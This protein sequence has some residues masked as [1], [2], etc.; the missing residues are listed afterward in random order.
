[1]DNN[2]KHQST[3]IASLHSHA[4]R[5]SSDIA[6]ADEKDSLTYEQLWTSITTKNFAD[7]SRPLWIANALATGVPFTQLLLACQYHQVGHIS[8]PNDVTPYEAERYLDDLP[9]DF[10]FCDNN[11]AWLD[12]SPAFHTHQTS[13]IANHPWQALHDGKWVQFTSG[14]TGRPKALILNQSAMNANL[15][16]HKNWLKQ[17]EGTSVF[18]PM[19]QFHAMGGA[20]LQEYL[21]AGAS[22]HVAK[23]SMPGQ[24][25]KRMQQANVRLIVA[26]PSYFRML[27]TLKALNPDSLPSLEMVEIGSASVHRSLI[28]ALLAAYPSLSIRIRYGQSEAS[29]SLTSLIINASNQHLFKDGAIGIP[30]E[31]IDISCDEH[32]KELH[33][34]APTCAT[35][36]WHDQQLKP[37]LG[38]STHELSTGDSASYDS[39][40]NSWVIEG[41]QSSFIKRNGYRIN[42]E[43]IE[44]AMMQM[45]QVHQAIAVP[46]ADATAGANIVVL[47]QANTNQPSLSIPELIQ[48]ARTHLSTYKWPQRFFIVPNAPMTP[49]GKPDRHNAQITT[50]HLIGGARTETSSPSTQ[51]SEVVL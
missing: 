32:R 46:I 11:S 37:V 22:L 7:T 28:D 38:T 44:T 20:V 29:G 17:W 9:I 2:F 41:R 50:N 30:T 6:I 49:S 31:G 26:P 42:P 16:L 13:L 24:D 39:E 34:K 40:L 19:P 10:G 18:C 33:F 1:M 14:S 36:Q 5:R 21:Y 43:D 35:Y 51:S 25:L 47:V 12:L 4:H 3:L 8:L 15:T 48:H 27:L 23:Q 45:P